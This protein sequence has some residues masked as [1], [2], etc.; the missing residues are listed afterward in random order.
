M[1]RLMLSIEIAEPLDQATVGP[2]ANLHNQV[3]SNPAAVHVRTPFQLDK[4]FLG[5]PAYHLCRCARHNLD[6]KAIAAVLLICWLP[7]TTSNSALLGLL[8]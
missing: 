2:L 4:V 8:V 3:P 6:G 7:C 1:F 5:A